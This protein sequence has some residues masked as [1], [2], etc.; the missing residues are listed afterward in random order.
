MAGQAIEWQ[1]TALM[2]LDSWS[3]AILMIHLH[4]KQLSFLLEKSKHKP[5]LVLLCN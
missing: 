3:L 1:E 5:V 2:M 4:P